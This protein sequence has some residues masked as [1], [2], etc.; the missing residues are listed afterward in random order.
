MQKI[1]HIP[2][3]LYIKAFLMECEGMCL[4]VQLAVDA[5]HTVGAGEGVADAG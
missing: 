2:F 3:T 4:E 5:E 1:P